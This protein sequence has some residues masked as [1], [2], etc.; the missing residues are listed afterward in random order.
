MPEIGTKTKYTFLTINYNITVHNYKILNTTMLYRV[1][2]AARNR[3][4]YPK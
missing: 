4:L 1:N 2:S 3:I